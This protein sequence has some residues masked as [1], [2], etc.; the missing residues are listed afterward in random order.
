MYCN[1]DVDLFGIW[2]TFIPL[3]D[4][5]HLPMAVFSVKICKQ[6]RWTIFG[7]T[8]TLINFSATLLLLRKT[9]APFLLQI[10]LYFKAN[11][12]SKELELATCFR[13]SRHKICKSFF[14]NKVA[15]LRPA[16]LLKKTLRHRSFPM[17]F[18]N[19]LRTLFYIKHLW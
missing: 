8:L 14:F 16:T 12:V 1:C 6:L 7:K 18:A 9:S 4:S 15:G 19:P 10:S 17:N 3:I 5:W 2:A 13:N 11:Q